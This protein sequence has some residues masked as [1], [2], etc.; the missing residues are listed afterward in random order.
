MS[1]QSKPSAN[2]ADSDRRMSASRSAIRHLCTSEGALLISVAADRLTSV[3]AVAAFERELR[4]LLRERTEQHWLIDF[5][6]TT[7]FITPAVNT[8][9]AILRTL[10][11]RNG[12][13]VL[14]GLNRDVRRI[15]GLRRLDSVLTICPNVTAACRELGVGHLSDEPPAGA[16]EAG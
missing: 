13:L 2:Q 4:R 10:R 14:T 3:E 9:L 7:F 15:L 8:L 6:N 16:A 11:E 12:K 5:G 1:S